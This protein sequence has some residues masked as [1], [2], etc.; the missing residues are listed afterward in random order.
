MFVLPSFN[1]ITTSLKAA[2]K[3]LGL[4]ILA[5]YFVFSVLATF[6]YSSIAS[7]KAV[8]ASSTN[9]VSSYYQTASEP[10]STDSHATDFADTQSTGEEGSEEE[11]GLEDGDKALFAK[12]HSFHPGYSTLT[13]IDRA[14]VLTPFQSSDPTRPPRA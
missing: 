5:L 13:Y 9:Q 4:A 7:S 10:L 2:G 11:S 14:P 3:S 6:G 8:F 12:A 1:T